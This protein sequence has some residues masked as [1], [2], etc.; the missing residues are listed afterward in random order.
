MPQPQMKKELKRIGKDAPK[1]LMP[2]KQ[3]YTGWMIG[4][5]VLIAIIAIALYLNAN[6]KSPNPSPTAAPTLTSTLVPTKQS[7]PTPFATATPTDEPIPTITRLEI[8]KCGTIKESITLQ[9]D[10]ESQ[11]TCL[12]IASQ[13][14]TI[15]CNGFKIT[16]KTAENSSAI[17]SEF[18]KTSVKNCVISSYELGIRLFKAD[19]STLEDNVLTANIG[20]MLLQQ[21]SGLKILRNQF[22][23][24]SEGAIILNSVE[25]SALE[26]NFIDQSTRYG[27]QVV[28]SSDNTLKGNLIYRNKFGIQLSGSSNNLILANNVS[29]N[30]AGIKITSRSSGNRIEGNYVLDNQGVG[31]HVLDSFETVIKGN[32]FSGNEYGINMLDWITNL[33]D[34]YACGNSIMDIYCEAS[35]NATG[36]ICE[37]RLTAC[38]FDCVRKCKTD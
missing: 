35:Q 33:E 18:A 6:Q 14:V 26:G 4:A 16:G 36:N 25:K 7:T 9:N 15:D 2:Y 22:Y 32:T 21:S 8:S 19:S 11:G 12:T 27:I 23:N 31:L 38:G 17:Y 24:S 1:A 5:L 34:N 20:G 3:D 30:S 10:L 13:G 28:G 29:F 37:Q